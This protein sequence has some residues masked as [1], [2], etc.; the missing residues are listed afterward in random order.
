MFVHFV[1]NHVFFSCKY[2]IKQKHM[3]KKKEEINL[4]DN[5]VTCCC[6]PDHA[7]FDLTF[8]IT[9]KTLPHH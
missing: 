7:R 4:S 9:R 5:I 6:H 1:N 8:M 3:Y 2:F